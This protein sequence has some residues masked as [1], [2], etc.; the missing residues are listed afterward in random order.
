[1]QYGDFYHIFSV[2]GEKN[3]EIRCIGVSLFIVRKKGS[4]EVKKPESVNRRRSP[5]GVVFC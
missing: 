2:P 1:M 3:I 5:M 4:L